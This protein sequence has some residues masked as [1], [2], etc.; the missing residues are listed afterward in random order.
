LQFGPELDGIHAEAYQ[1]DLRP[2]LSAELQDPKQKKLDTM[3]MQPPPWP[4]KSKHGVSQ[5]AGLLL[6]KAD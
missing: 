2:V 6:G 4:S 3:V 1:M 5:L